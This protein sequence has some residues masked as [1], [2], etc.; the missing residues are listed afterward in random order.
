MVLLDL[1][2][3][4]RFGA[5]EGVAF[6]CAALLWSVLYWDFALITMLGSNI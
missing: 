3:K 6:M 5:A 2:D 1:R 4:R